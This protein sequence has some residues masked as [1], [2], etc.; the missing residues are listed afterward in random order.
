MKHRR[1]RDAWEDIPADA[2]IELT[3]R[4]RTVC[5]LSVIIAVLIWIPIIIW[6]KS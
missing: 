1:I 6:L 5:F 3:P 4:Q 2:K